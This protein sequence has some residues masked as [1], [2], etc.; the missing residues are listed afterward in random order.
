MPANKTGSARTT[1]ILKMLLPT[2]LPTRRSHSSLRA[3]VIVVTNSGSDVPRAIMVSEIMRSDTPMALAIN[4]AELT[5]NWL[6][7]T[8]PTSPMTT[9]SRDLPSLYL[10]ASTSFAPAEA[11]RLRRAMAIR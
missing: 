6:P 10:G 11:W 1:Q 4:E 8:T 3:A 2:M 9:R 7:P 5:T